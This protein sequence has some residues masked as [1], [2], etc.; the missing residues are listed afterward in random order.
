MV[1]SSCITDPTVLDPGIVIDLISK[2]AGEI[3]WLAYREPL[4]DQCL[5]LLRTI[6]SG[7]LIPQDHSP[8]IIDI[9]E[10]VLLEVMGGRGCCNRVQVQADSGEP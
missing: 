6:Q 9:S 3:T 8:P 4:F 2:D 10:V 1:W 7:D 5:D